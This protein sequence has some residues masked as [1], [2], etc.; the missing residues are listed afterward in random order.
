MKGIKQVLMGF[1][2]WYNHRYSCNVE[3]M[4]AVHFIRQLKPDELR[5][6]ETD[7]EYC[8]HGYEYN[9]C[10]IHNYSRFGCLSCMADK[11]YENEVKKLNE[12]AVINNEAEASSDGVAVCPTCGGQCYIG[13]TDGET[14]YF[15]PVHS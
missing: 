13:G 5:N 12:P 14:R 7:K 15:I 8:E 6:A 2:V 3:I 10:L 11:Q 9:N 1:I 4:D